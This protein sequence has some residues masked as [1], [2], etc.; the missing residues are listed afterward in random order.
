MRRLLCDGIEKPFEYALTR[1]VTLLVVLASVK[2]W[3]M[4]VLVGWDLPVI[5][6]NWMSFKVFY[7]IV[8]YNDFL[9]CLVYFVFVLAVVRVFRGENFFASAVVYAVTFFLSLYALANIE[10]YRVFGD[11]FDFTYYSGNMLRTAFVRSNLSSVRAVVDVASFL[12]RLGAAC[13]FI[14]FFPHVLRRILS[15]TSRVDR[16]V[17]LMAAAAL[18]TIILASSVISY[19]MYER[20][21]YFFE[22]LGDFTVFEKNI[23]FTLAESYFRVFHEAGDENVKPDLNLFL[24]DESEY[25]YTDAARPLVKKRIAEYTE[26]AERLNVIV[27][28]LESFRADSMQVFGAPVNNT[29]NLEKLADH[30]ILFDNFYVNSPLSAK[31]LPTIL[32]SVYPYPNYKKIVLKRQN[33]SL[34]CLPDVLKSLGYSTA[35]Y[36]TSYL[37]YYHDIDF[38]R[39]R[40]FDTI[41]TAYNFSET[42]KTKPK[43]WGYDDFE[44]VEPSIAWMRERDSPFLM[45]YYTQSTH[46]PFTIPDGNYVYGSEDIG[47]RYLSAIHYTDAFIGELLKRLG[48]ENLLEDTLLVFIGDHGQLLTYETTGFEMYYLYQGNLHVPLMITVP[49]S[50]EKT[51]SHDL[52]SMISLVPTILDILRINTEN[53]FQ[54]ESLLKEK[55]ETVYLVSSQGKYIGV[56]EGELKV[57]VNPETMKVSVYNVSVGDEEVPEA[58]QPE[59]TDELVKKAITWSITQNQLLDRELIW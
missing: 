48:Q 1:A 42:L 24:F 53:P 12:A 39:H 38:M 55:N 40:G 26:E 37:D 23:Y 11:V 54:G 22:K 51:M 14:L 47:D 20:Y 33:M 4:L 8:F 7:P 34:L 31:S 28:I 32:C 49:G 25:V 13:L 10:F 45:Y 9:F 35:F 36:T 21:P 59:N 16:R 15:K 50:R 29:P 44:L 17:S 41:Y 58:N 5:L 56:I 52:S 46:H 6:G 2:A 57:V 27:F 18:L 19:S 43:S 30:S 3:Q